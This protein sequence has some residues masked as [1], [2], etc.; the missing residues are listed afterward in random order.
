MSASAQRRRWALYEEQ[1]A[2]D[3][4]ALDAMAVWVAAFFAGLAWRPDILR[5]P[6]L[7]RF[8]RQQSGVVLASRLRRLRLPEPT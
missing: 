7:R 1:F 3:P 6:R 5:L 4:D 8:Q 2:L